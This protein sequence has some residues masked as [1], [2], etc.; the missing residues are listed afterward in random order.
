[1]V[2]NNDPETLATGIS[3]FLSKPNL[4]E[5]SILINRASVSQFSWAHIADLVIKELH[6]VLDG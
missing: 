1:M 3:R 6:K 2:A 5:E 4:D